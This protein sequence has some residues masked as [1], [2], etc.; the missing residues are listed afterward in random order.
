MSS[1]NQSC[2]KFHKT[3]Q[4]F[5]RMFG[6]DFQVNS[7]V[8]DIIPL[9]ALLGCRKF[10]ENSFELKI[11]YKII[12]SRQA[13]QLSSNCYF[14]E[15]RNKHYLGRISTSIKVRGIFALLSVKFSKTLR[16]C[17]ANLPL[18]VTV[19]HKELTAMKLEY[20]LIWNLLICCFILLHQHVWR[21]RYI[22]NN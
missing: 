5:V 21:Y 18:R 10:E 11:Y 19:K 3:P 16:I 22:D 20:A 17:N 4:R 2:W 12:A 13:L 8:S 6:S 1:V 7:W 14:N 9:Q 15:F